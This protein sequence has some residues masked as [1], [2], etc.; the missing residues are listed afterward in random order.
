MKLKILA[1]LAFGGFVLLGNYLIQTF[2]F[3]S[4]CPKCGNP[5]PD[6]ARRPQILRRLP[7]RAYHCTACGK[8]FYHIGADNNLTLV[9]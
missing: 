8:R 5:H 1:L 6:R 2:R 9:S 7:Y 3:K 4:D